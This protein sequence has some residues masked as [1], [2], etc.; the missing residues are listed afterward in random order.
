MEKVKRENGKQS[1][2][3]SF[4]GQVRL[5]KKKKKKHYNNNENKNAVKLKC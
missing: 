5:K 1:Q 2:R 3:T 4:K